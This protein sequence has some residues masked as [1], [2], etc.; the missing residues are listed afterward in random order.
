MTT[1]GRRLSSQRRDREA[2]GRSRG[3]L[4]TKIHLLADR[5]CRPVARVTT[6][7]QR[8]D[9]LAFE[10]LM[11]RLRI[12]RAGPGRPRTRPGRLLGDKAYSNKKIRAHLRRRRITATIP[13]P[14]DQI[15][16]RVKRGVKGGRPPAFDAVAYKD[17]TPPSVLSTSSRPSAQWPC[18]P[19]N[20]TTSTEAP[21]TS[22]RS[23]S[24]SATQ[25]AK[26]HETR[27]SPTTCGIA[28]VGRSYRAPVPGDMYRGARSGRRTSGLP[29]RSV[30]RIETLPLRTP[31]Y[32]VTAYRTCVAY[33]ELTALTTAR[34]TSRSNPSNSRLPVP[35][36]TGAVESTS[37]STRPAASA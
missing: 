37:S 25:S 26:I 21:L 11:N 22:P 30:W 29:S 36:I 9:S 17:R 23:R 18:A 16:H 12:A 19:A 10:P 4:T 34:L 6:A 27:P 35:R 3:G 28:D 13:E 24:G 31:A 5:R 2:L 7:G 20:A 32:F 15:A 8:H 14:A 33:G 1:I